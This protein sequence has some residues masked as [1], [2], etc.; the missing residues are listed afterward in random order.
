MKLDM[1]FEGEAWYT[2]E[3]AWIYPPSEAAGYAEGAG[4][5]AGPAI[6]GELRWSNRA[7]RRSDGI[8]FV[9]IRGYITTS[10]RARILLRMSGRSLPEHEPQ[11]TR[12]VVLWASLECEDERYAWLGDVAAVVEGR[13]DPRRGSLRLRV[14]GCTNELPAEEDQVVHSMGRS[15][16]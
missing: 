4:A 12:D 13:F 9:D 1:L 7:R 6:T 5:I 10:D 11:Q 8:W 3:G 2:T 16:L 14:F 15:G